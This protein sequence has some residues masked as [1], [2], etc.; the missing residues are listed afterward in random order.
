[1]FLQLYIHNLYY[2]DKSSFR[3]EVPHENKLTDHMQNYS[4]T[5]VINFQFMMF[6]IDLCLLWSYQSNFLTYSGNIS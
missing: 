3:T 1:M 2:Q 4:S 5:Y 6:M